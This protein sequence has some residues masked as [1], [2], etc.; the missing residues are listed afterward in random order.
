MSQPSQA[1]W[2]DTISHQ[3]EALSVL[4]S[5]NHAG[6]ADSRW[7]QTPT[8]GFLLGGM[9]MAALGSRLSI[10]EPVYKFIVFA[11]LMKIGL[12]GGIEIR[13]ANLAELLLPA[14]LTTIAGISDRD[15]RCYNPRQAA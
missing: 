11:L 4:W 15:H 8:L 9:L 13:N 2:L 5:C 7:F 6:P 14:I 10:P 3:H 12:R 1:W